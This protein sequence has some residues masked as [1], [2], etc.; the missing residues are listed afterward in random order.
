M[1]VSSLESSSVI[2]IFTVSIEF[3][4]FLLI[5]AFFANT[6]VFSISLA[7][8]STVIRELLLFCFTE[9]AGSSSSCSID[10]ALNISLISL[11]VFTLGFSFIINVGSMLCFMQLRTYSHSKTCCDLSNISN[12]YSP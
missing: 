11:L 6:W 9:L 3:S 8:D 10:F 7:I 2:V 4:L 5:L 1:L 12:P